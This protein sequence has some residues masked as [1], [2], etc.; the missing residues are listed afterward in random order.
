MEKEW[1]HK[2]VANSLY[3]TNKSFLIC[4]NSYQADIKQIT[5]IFFIS[6]RHLECYR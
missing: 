6:L 2:S 3:C 5:V 1:G 4:T